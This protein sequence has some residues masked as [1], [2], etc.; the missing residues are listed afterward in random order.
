MCRCGRCPSVFPL[1][2]WVKRG[3]AVRCSREFTLGDA[4]DLPGFNLTICNGST[5]RVL[6]VDD[7]HVRVYAGANNN[8]TPT[9]S[10]FGD[11]VEPY[12]FID[13]LRGD[14]DGIWE[15]DPPVNP[16]AVCGFHEQNDRH[17]NGRIHENLFHE[18]VPHA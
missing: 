15:Q 2:E 10:G 13:H 9:W 11:P 16:C 12:L 18:F 6:R 5:G 7:A 3:A 4:G 14:F 1:K 8:E 17:C